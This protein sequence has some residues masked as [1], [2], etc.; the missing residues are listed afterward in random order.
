MATQ[1]ANS[2]KS[3]GAR[4]FRTVGQSLPELRPGLTNLRTS[5]NALCLVS[6]QHPYRGAVRHNDAGNESKLHRGYAVTDFRLTIGM[7]F[8]SA[9]SFHLEV[10]NERN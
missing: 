5:G 1:Q 9:A 3:E 2:N 7:Y 10:A 8:E 6:P 4:I